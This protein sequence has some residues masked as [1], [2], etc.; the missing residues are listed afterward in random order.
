MST[1]GRGK[2]SIA[3]PPGCSV[4]PAASIPR[5][6]CV[7]PKDGP[8]CQK[9]LLGDFCPEPSWSVSHLTWPLKATERHH[10]HEMYEAAA[11]VTQPVILQST[12]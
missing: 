11:T 6:I 3:K 5:Y 9:Y 2:G 1:C 4:S 12:H 8:C 7:L 10:S